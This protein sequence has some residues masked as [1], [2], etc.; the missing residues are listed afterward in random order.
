M[1]PIL[2]TFAAGLILGL[3]ATAALA[4][5]HSTAGDEAMSTP[6]ADDRATYEESISNDIAE[7]RRELAEMDVSATLNDAWGEVQADWAALEEATAENWQAAR[8]TFEESWESFQQE[9]NEAT[10]S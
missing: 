7:T 9:W 5:D 4:D 6:G 8:E 1:K 3:G 2:G 10:A